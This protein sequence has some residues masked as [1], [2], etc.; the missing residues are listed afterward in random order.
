MMRGKEINH[1]EGEE[2]TLGFIFMHQKEINSLSSTSVLIDT[3]WTVSVFRNKELQM[4]I[5]KSG[6]S[7]RAH[8]QDMV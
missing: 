2:D 1:E 5:T 6:S 8:F 3:G 7:L 4:N